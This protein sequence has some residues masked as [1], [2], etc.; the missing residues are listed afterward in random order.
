MTEKRVRDFVQKVR[1]SKGDTLLRLSVYD[2]EAQVSLGLY[3]KTHKVSLSQSLVG[4][5]DDNH[6]RYS[7]A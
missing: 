6:I 5:L 4:F 2:R 1:E 3:S 7:I